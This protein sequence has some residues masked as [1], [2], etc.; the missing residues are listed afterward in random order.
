MTH[1][2]ADLE[3]NGGCAGW[4]PGP[5][6][7]DRWLGRRAGQEPPGRARTF[8]QGEPPSLETACSAEL[9]GE[10]NGDFSVLGRVPKPA[11]RRK[12]PAG[13]SGCSLPG[14]CVGHTSSSAFS[15]DYREAARA[16]LFCFELT[17][18]KHLQGATLCIHF[19]VLEFL[20][21]SQRSLRNVC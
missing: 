2:D 11:R 7:A 16:G 1:Q 8:S 10:R 13:L 4:S 20:Q 5:V 21:S 14:P 15:G 3:K 18:K 6:P 9:T 19:Y 17:L 12:A